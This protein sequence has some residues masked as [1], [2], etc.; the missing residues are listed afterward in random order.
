MIISYKW[1]QT[2]FENPLPSPDKVAETLTFGVFEVEST[3]KK[4]DDTIFDV[5]VLPDRAHDCLSHRGIARELASLLRMPLKAESAGVSQEEHDTNFHIAVEDTTLCRRYAGRVVR[6]IKVGLSPKWLCERLESI[7]QRSVN[8][9]VDATN[10]VMFDIG[11]PLH[12]FDKDKLSEGGIFVRSAKTGERITTLDGKEVFLDE[13]MLV[14]A[15][16]E[17]P[18]AIAGVKGG[19]KAEV[20]ERTTTIV[21]EAANFDPALVRKTSRRLDIMTDS[22]KRFEHEITPELAGEAM[23][24]VT[25]LIVQVAGGQETTVERTIDAYPKPQETRTI[26]MTPADA[27]RLLGTQLSKEQMGMLLLQLQ[28][29]FVKEKDSD[30]FSVTIPAERLDIKEKADIVEDIGHVYGYENIP[31]V[32]PTEGVA[33]VN[34]KFYCMNVIRGALVK[35]GFSEVY[36]YTFSAEGEVELENPLA[37]DRSF[38]RANLTD[39]ILGVLSKNAMNASILGKESMMVFEFGTVFH[40]TGEKILLAVGVHH[41]KKT[42][43]GVLRVILAQLAEEIG[44]PSLPVIGGYNLSDGM[45]EVV[46][47]DMDALVAA[48][49]EPEGTYLFPESASL[50]YKPFSPYPFIARDIAV[51]V[52][53]GTAQSAVTDIILAECG[54]LI[55]QGPTLFDEFKKDGKVSYAFRFVF[56]SQERTLT[57]EEVNMVMERIYSQIRALGFTVR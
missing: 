35:E 6:G 8:N 56:Q 2:Y 34:K 15:D 9:V 28:F 43:E 36:G 1:L 30:I 46:V 51:W 40:K 18:L 21:L 48:L 11:Q 47:I 57:D 29:S 32:V 50:Q 31:S 41:L 39:G 5:K 33:A 7:G 49:P 12:A 17:A 22:S 25:A 13:G 37:R 53:E 44:A 26:A 3:E 23:E 45:R 55:V 24:R 10:Y 4:G 16:T 38:L 14:I 54:A 42:K 19:I 20:G 27:N 52:P